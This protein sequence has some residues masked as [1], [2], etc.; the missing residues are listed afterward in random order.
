MKEAVD[1]DEEIY[2]DYTKD[3]YSDENYR[4]DIFIAYAIMVKKYM[5][6]YGPAIVLGIIGTG[7]ILYG[8]NILTKRNVAIAAAYE[9]VKE[10]YS[11]YRKRVVEELGEE[12][13][14][15]F[16]YGV[17]KKDIDIE[18]EK[19]DGTV[20]KKNKKQKNQQNFWR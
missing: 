1:S 6:L 13:D 10:G 20:K 19:E 15:R 3:T 8:H 18:Q 14:R 9:A 4:K 5:R 12:A 7:S 11:E 2:K 17:Q 16:R